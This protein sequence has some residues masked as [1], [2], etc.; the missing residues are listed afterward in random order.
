MPE[1][2]SRAVIADPQA[3]QGPESRLIRQRLSSLA[4]Q[5]LRV[6]CRRCDRLIEIQK[7]DA[8]RLYGEDASVGDVTRKLLGTVCEMR[9]GRHEEDGCWP[10]VRAL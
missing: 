7:A 5:I 4:G 8:I 9:T 3:Q 2:Y 6:S 1:E 10:T